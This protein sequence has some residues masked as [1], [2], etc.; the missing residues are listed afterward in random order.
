[1]TKEQN[2]HDST[3]V[4]GKA[5]AAVASKYKQAKRNQMEGAAS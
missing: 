4:Q 2:E 3:N 5:A 1:M